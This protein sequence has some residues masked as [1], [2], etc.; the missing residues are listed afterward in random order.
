M[1]VLSGGNTRPPFGT[2][3]NEPMTRSMSAAFSTGLGTSSIAS[4][5]AMARMPAGN[6]HRLCTLGLAT[7]A[8]ASEA[9]CNLLEHR[10][11][12]AGDARLILQQPSEIAARPRQARDEA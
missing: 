6:G 5:G 3:A 8:A 11:P 10:Q 1:V 12:L 9:R 7:R 4:D 2:R